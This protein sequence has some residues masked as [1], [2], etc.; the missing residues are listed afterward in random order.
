MSKNAYDEY[1]SYLQ[2]TEHI[3]SNRL[4]TN[5]FFIS[6]NT[7]LVN[8]YT[9]TGV[10]IEQL[11]LGVV[12]CLIWYLLLKSYKTLNSAKFKTIKEVAKKYKFLNLYYIEN[13]IL[14]HKNYYY[15]S[16]LESIIPILFIIYYC[17]QAISIIWIYFYKRCLC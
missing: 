7:F 13:K 12:L 16:S 10:K 8:Y 14:K 3:T 11:L 15:L 1:K 5:A 4:R 17:I 6:I 2:T 9:Q